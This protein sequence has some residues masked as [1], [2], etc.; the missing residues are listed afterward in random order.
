ML[1]KV[2]SGGQTGVDTYGLMAAKLYS[3]ETGGHCPK[4]YRTEQGNEPDRLKQYG[5][6]ET[7]EYGYNSRTTL[8]VK[9]SDGTVLYGNMDSPGTKLTL[10]ILRSTKKPFITNPTAD[11]LVEFINSNNISVLNVAGNRE[12]KLTPGDIVIIAS[13][14]GGAFA[15][16]TG[17]ELKD[18]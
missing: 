3:L 14:L 9:N 10:D 7:T 15:K 16:I 2:I 12:S 4:G 17:K 18:L 6:E 5:L 11:Q 8:N 13:S 1:K